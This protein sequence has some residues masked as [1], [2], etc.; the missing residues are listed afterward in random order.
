MNNPIKMDDLGGPPLFLETSIWS[1]EVR[2]IK[3]HYKQVT[4]VISLRKEY[5]YGPLPITG[6]SGPLIPYL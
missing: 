3:G 5:N 6:W 1:Y 2:I 4:G